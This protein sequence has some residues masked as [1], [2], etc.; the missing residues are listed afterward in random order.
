MVELQKC[1]CRLTRKKK[2]IK[3]VQIYAPTKHSEEEVWYEDCSCMF[4]FWPH[5][6]FWSNKFKVFRSLAA[7]MAVAVCVYLKKSISLILATFRYKP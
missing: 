7:Q 1:C 2:K 3:I 5:F 4:N 6:F